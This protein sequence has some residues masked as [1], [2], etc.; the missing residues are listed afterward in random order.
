MLFMLFFLAA[1]L[2]EILTFSNAFYSC[3]VL[4]VQAVVIGDDYMKCVAVTKSKWKSYEIYSK[5]ASYRCFLS[6]V[7]CVMKE[8]RRSNEA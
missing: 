3:E 2:K 7:K 1:S 8:T 4:L 5:H 6:K